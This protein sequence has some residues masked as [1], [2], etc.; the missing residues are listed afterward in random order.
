[1]NETIKTSFDFNTLMPQQ[2]CKKKLGKKPVT[3]IY[4]QYAI[5]LC[6]FI[7]WQLLII[8]VYIQ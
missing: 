8:G 7:G 4:L 5:C 2:S 6:S 3:L 1:M